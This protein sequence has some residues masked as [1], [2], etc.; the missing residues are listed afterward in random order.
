M[1]SLISLISPDLCPSISF[2]CPKGLETPSLPD[3]A[4]RLASRVVKSEG[5]SADGKRRTVLD[6]EADPKI[7]KSSS[8]WKCGSIDADV[9]G[10]ALRDPH[11][12]SQSLDTSAFG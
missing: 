3:L 7:G 2:Q 12:C 1:L 5:F 6:D 4:T 10:G 8:E 11:V 9:A